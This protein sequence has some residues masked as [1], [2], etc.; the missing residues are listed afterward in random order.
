MSEEKSMG[1][2]A[3][4]RADRA[5]LVE[6]FPGCFLPKGAP[7]K[8]P[9]ARGILAYLLDNP[10]IDSQ[11]GAMSNTRIR[12][13]V[14]DYVYGA[15]YLAALVAGGWRINLNGEIEGY[16]TEHESRYALRELLSKHTKWIERTGYE[17]PLRLAA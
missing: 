15:K 16:V 6:Q 1:K 12:A 13:A 11:G 5:I 4:V 14:I 7:G 3:R 9:L 10:P 8:F 2:Y 17:P